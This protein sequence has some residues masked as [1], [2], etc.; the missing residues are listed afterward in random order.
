[1]VAPPRSLGSP[2]NN[3]DNERIFRHDLSDQSF[4]RFNYVVINTL[5]APLDRIAAQWPDRQ[6]EIPD[7]FKALY[8]DHQAQLCR[9]LRSSLYR[10]W[11][12]ANLGA[13]APDLSQLIH[14]ESGRLIIKRH[15]PV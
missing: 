14:F 1:M 11:L 13:L 3:E 6:E 8:G 7:R 10:S 15:Y 2:T 12:A 4:H 9:E 5:L